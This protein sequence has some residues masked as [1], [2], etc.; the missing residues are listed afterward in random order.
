MGIMHGCGANYDAAGGDDDGGVLNNY[1]DEYG[2]GLMT[3][4]VMA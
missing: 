2:D 1:D 4:V 3:N